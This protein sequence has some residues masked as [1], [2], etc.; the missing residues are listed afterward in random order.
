MSV[1]RS[2]TFGLFAV[3]FVSAGLDYVSL[4]AGFA[5]LSGP[6]AVVASFWAL[7]SSLAVTW[8]VIVRSGGASSL[9]PS[10]LHRHAARAWPLFLAACACLSAAVCIALA[11]A[12]FWFG[13]TLLRVGAYGSLGPISI[14]LGTVW[15]VPVAATLLPT[16]GAAAAGAALA[17]ARLR[18][19][20]VF[21]TAAQQP[22]SLQ[23]GGRVDGFLDAVATA[24]APNLACGVAGT[25]V[26]G[27]IAITV[28][29][30]DTA[31]RLLGAPWMFGSAVGVAAAG[32]ACAAAAWHLSSGAPADP[33]A[34]ERAHLDAE[35]DSAVLVAMRPEIL[36][37]SVTSP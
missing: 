13:A 8:F 26:L 16:A 1:C 4:R 20:A 35:S 31:G 17:A 29:R 10:T 2:V 27:A 9:P 32:V 37:G 19:L 3:F 7:A 15:G 11:P 23:C 14:L 12:F 33:A 34:L 6:M 28:G 25:A 36:T 24:A 21:G 18:Q 30:I 5:S 22:P